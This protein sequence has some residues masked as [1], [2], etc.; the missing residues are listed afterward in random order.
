MTVVYSL[1]KVKH[2][3]VLY[4]TSLTSLYSLLW[5]RNHSC[6]MHLISERHG[7]AYQL[8]NN[9]NKPNIIGIPTA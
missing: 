5:S 7:P 2:Y 1:I 4:G 8:V 6:A 3:M 9:R